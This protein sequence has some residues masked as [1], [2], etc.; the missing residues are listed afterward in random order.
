L[1]QHKEIFRVRGLINSVLPNVRACFKFQMGAERREKGEG[2]RE[3]G[4][5]LFS[6]CIHL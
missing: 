6:F 4:I 1:S 5:R 3:K 2:R